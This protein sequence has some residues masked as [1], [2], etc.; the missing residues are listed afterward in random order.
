MNWQHAFVAQEANCILQ[1]IKKSMTS[2][3]REVIQPLYS[4]LVITHL[5]Y[6]N[7]FWGPQYKKDIE[8]LKRVQG[9]ATKMIRGLEHLPLQGQSER[10][11]AFQ[12]AKREGSGETL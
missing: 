12:P 3:W 10:V 11:G 4:A 9:R 2:R 1:C 5:E 6:C 7:Q 8:M